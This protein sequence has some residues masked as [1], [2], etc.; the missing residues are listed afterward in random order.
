M[1]YTNCTKTTSY[2]NYNF[3]YRG[4]ISLLSKPKI[5]IVGSRKPNQYAK[6]ITAQLSKLLSHKYVIVSGGAMGIDAI[7]HQN[8]KS[9]IMVSPSGLDKIYP[10]TNK[11]IIE[12]MMQNH[13]VI[14]EYEDGFMPYKY[15]F[16][17]RNKVLID[18]S[19]FVIITYATENSGSIRSFE[20]AQQLNKKVYVI[21]HQIGHSI[22][23]NKL[24]SQ[25]L[26]EVIWD[27][28][29]FAKEL[30]IN[31]QSNIM[32]FN[33]AYRIYKDKLYEMELEGI[34]EIK[35]SKVYFL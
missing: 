26:A 18:I 1:N 34:V 15:T 33:E 24:A 29:A 14:S 3:Y 8:A 30:N 28:D 13:L 19:D 35:N 6:T 21:P 23:T 31:Q 11:A 12:D 4:D 16:I 27:I 7:A 25:Q 22:G 20:I 2:R 10:K 5:A 9:T 17:Q 32:D